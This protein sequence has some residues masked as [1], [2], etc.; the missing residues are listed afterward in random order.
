MGQKKKLTTTTTKNKFNKF[1][2]IEE[3]SQEI[4][5]LKPKKGKNQKSLTLFE[6]LPISKKTKKGL[7]ESNYTKMTDIQQKSI[8]HALSGK[9]ILGASKTGSGK[10]LAFL[11]PLIEN[12]YRK[13]WTTFDGLGALILTPSRELALQIFEVLRTFAKYHMFSCGLVVGGNKK[14]EEEKKFVIGMNILVATPGRLLQHLDETYGFTCDNLEILVLDEADRLLELGFE[15]ELNAIIKNIPKTRQTILFSAT[16]TSKVKDLTRL[17]LNKKN[18]EYISVIGK[19]VTPKNLNQSYIQCELYEKIDVLFSFVKSHTKSKIIVFCSSQKQVSF[20][21]TIFHQLSLGISIHKLSGNMSQNVRREN[22]EEFLSKHFS[23]LFCTDVASRGLDFPRV[24]F[25]IQIDL[26][27]NLK[28][29]IHRVGRTARNNSQGKSILFILKEEIEFINQIEKNNIQIKQTKVN[30]NRTLSIKDQLSAM[31]SHDVKLKYLAMKYFDSY[32]RS[33]YKGC[34]AIKLDINNLP[35]KEFSE[36]LGLID[37]PNF[38]FLE[39]KNVSDNDD[40]S[41]D[42]DSNN[43]DDDELILGKEKKTR[44]KN[45]DKITSKKNIVIFSDA[46]KKLIKNEQND[47]Q[48]ED[49]FELKR[50]NHELSDNEDNTIQNKNYLKKKQKHIIFKDGK[51][52]SKFEALVE[53]KQKNENLEEKKNKYL[54]NLSKNLEENEMEDKMKFRENIRERRKKKLEH[55]KELRDLKKQISL[56]KEGIDPSENKKEKDDKFVVTLASDDEWIED[57]EGKSESESENENDN[58]KRKRDNSNEKKEIKLKKKKLQQE[59]NVA[60]ALLDEFLNKK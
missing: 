57:D 39:N 56:M 31:I 4:E 60:L 44:K 33:I 46:Y 10:T 24:D 1:T 12:L 47:E 15:K 18:T 9:D 17:S 55:E 40:S 45:I 14:V 6:E 37:I 54:E 26:P 13:K 32:L 8:L 41:D 11:I 59:E 21:S 27:L 36:R 25:V 52:L 38:S 50:E 42:N 35:L 7:N 43:D 23:L 29:Y 20:L 5:R 51:E 58:K 49:L 16:Q 2:E 34:T 28:S 48:D 3:L 53:E 19:E 30:S 22:Y